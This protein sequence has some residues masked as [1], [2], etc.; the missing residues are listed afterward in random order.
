MSYP[1]IGFLHKQMF[2]FN[3]LLIQAGLTVLNTFKG[4]AIIWKKLNIELDLFT[5][6]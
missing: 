2:I 5:P 6:Q 4:R 3:K 1:V